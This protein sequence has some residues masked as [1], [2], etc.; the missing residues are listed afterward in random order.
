[1]ELKTVS[2]DSCGAPL[3]IPAGA[4]FVT[5]NHCSAQLAVKHNE[6]VTFTELLG[7]IGQQTQRIAEDV[8]ELRYRQE[9]EDIDRQWEQER[10]TYMVSDKEGHRRVP[11]TSGSVIGGIVVVV[12]GIFWT[13][14]ATQAGA[15]GIFPVF[16]LLFIGFGIVVCISSFTKAQQYTAAEQRYRRRRSQ[17]QKR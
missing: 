1:V 12:F 10:Q 13:A 11:S 2:C 17:A 5:C 16:G 8:A 6:S 4:R 14:V 9:L 7:E 3:Q 15:P